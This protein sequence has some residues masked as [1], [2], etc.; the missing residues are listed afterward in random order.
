MW[1]TV[2]GWAALGYPPVA[3]APAVSP[4]SSTFTAYVTR[5][6]CSGGTTGSVSPPQVTSSG[7]EIVIT[8]DVE[9]M[10]PGTYA[11][12]GND[13]VAYEVDLGEPIGA[14]RL[15]DGAC[16]HPPAATTA[17]CL[18]GGVR[19]SPVAAPAP[20]TPVSAP[21]LPPS[22]DLDG[23]IPESVPMVIAEHLN[24]VVQAVRAEVGGEVFGGASF[25]NAANDAVTIY[26]TD[27]AAIEAAL[28]RIGSPLRDRVTVVQTTYTAA[29][30]EAYAAEAQAILDA[31]GIAGSA[32]VGFGVVD[33]VDVQIETSDGSPDPAL[34]AAAADALAGIPV[35]IS[36]RAPFVEL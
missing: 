35:S 29:E 12:P 16:A 26:G 5:L 33:A 23:V 34:E 36:F 25:T 30:I 31:A 28:D 10:P 8:F 19:W 1:L 24:S 13:L 7:A 22:L 18:D 2:D 27:A 21:S 3:E 17:F 15:V 14:R 20:S 9:P 6:S 32:G 11:C 4:D